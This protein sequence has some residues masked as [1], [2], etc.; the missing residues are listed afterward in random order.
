MP[1]TGQKSSLRILLGTARKTGFLRVCCGL[2]IYHLNKSKNV[3][4]ITRRRQERTVRTQKMVVHH[5][6]LV[7]FHVIEVVLVIPLTRGGASDPILEL[8]QKLSYYR[9]FIIF[10]SKHKIPTTHIKHT[11][12]TKQNIQNTKHNTSHANS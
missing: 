8:L 4:K 11:T 9:I 10:T 7:N 5:P 6:H 2:V 12:Y 3:I 1:R